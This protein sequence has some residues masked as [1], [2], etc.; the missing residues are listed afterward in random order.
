MIQVL[1]EAGDKRVFASAVDWP[2]W[3]RSGKTDDEA[4]RA[5][6]GYGHRYLVAVGP[7]SGF[8]PPD[9]V[10]ELSV[11]ERLRGG[12]TTDFGAPGAEAPTEGRPIDEAELR[13]L[14]GLLEQCWG[15]FDRSADAAMGR[16]LTKGP[17]GGGRER[18]AVVRHLVEAE[19]AYL[20][21]V[22]GSVRDL[23]GGDVGPGVRMVALRA[24]AWR[25]WPIVRPACPRR[26]TRDERRPSGRSATTFAGRPGM[27]STTP[28][29]SKTASSDR[30]LQDW[31]EPAD[32]A[33]AVG[34]RLDHEP[35]EDL[36]GR[37][38]PRPGPTARG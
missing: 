1:L 4:L 33:C 27:R 35:A 6:I 31:E 26:R 2:G 15:A 29:R 30:S 13:R 18:E 21:G 8:T 32:D 17:R 14:T 24:R 16:T 23:P 10:A 22:G 36:R 9:A 19:E 38:P 5:L 28:G 20:Q 3:S 11:V 25:P 37:P 7:G 12:A 34:R